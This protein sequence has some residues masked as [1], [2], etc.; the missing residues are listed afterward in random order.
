MKS[1]Y[2]VPLVTGTAMGLFGVLLVANTRVEV[3][4]AATA[5]V[6]ALEDPLVMNENALR[7]LQEREREARHTGASLAYVGVIFALA[8]VVATVLGYVGGKQ[9]VERGRQQWTIVGTKPQAARKE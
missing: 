5:C 1:K 6:Q 8:G 9:E 3:A 4:F 7:E 2:G